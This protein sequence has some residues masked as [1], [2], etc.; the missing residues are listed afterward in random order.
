MRKLAP[1]VVMLLLIGG[2]FA[3][4]QP[5]GV[6]AGQRDAAASRYR[7]AELP[8]AVPPGLR[9]A[10]VRDVNPAYRHM[11]GWI[12]SVGAGVGINDLTGDG[13]PDEMCLVDS[14]SDALIV[15]SVPGT[16]AAGTFQPFVLTPSPALPYDASTMAPMGCAPGDFNHDGLMDLLAYYWG[17]T[18]VLYM[19]KR[20]AKQL[21]ASAY[22]PVEVVPN[23]PGPGGRYSGPLWNTNAVAVADFDGDGRTDIVIGNY[24]PDSPV[25]GSHSRGKVVMP[26][27]LSR[28]TNGGGDIVLRWDG[29]TPSGAPEY[30]RARDPFPKGSATGWTLA[31]AAADL[32]GSMTPELYVAND[33][34]HDHLFVNMS[35]PGHIRFIEAKGKR[36][37]T[38]P[39]SKVLG[40][41]SF[42]G[43]GAD[44]TDLAGDGRFDILVSNITTSFG[45]Q[46]SN[47]TWMNTAGSEAEMRRDLRRGVAAFDDRSWPMGLAQSGWSWDVKAGDFA[48]RG[49]QDVLQTAGFVKGTVNRWAQLQEIATMNDNLVSDPSFWLNVKD[50]DDLAGDQCPAFFARAKNGR[51]TDL[52]RRL[53][54]CVPVPTRGISIADTRGN[55]AL[56]FAI[57]RQW[58]APSFYQNTAPRLG[59]HLS[60]RLV[61][62]VAGQRGPLQA[63][64][65]PA[66]GATVTVRTSTGKTMIDQVD[67]GGGHSGKNDFGLHYGLG[68]SRAPVSATVAWRDGNGQAHR[69][70][71]RLAPG[72]HTLLLGSTIQEVPAR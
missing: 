45:L 58:G 39:K 59:E 66:V 15:T 72:S 68:E 5:P 16:K 32:D 9:N 29:A 64:G 12:S 23:R 49:T 71:V 44:F 52:S 30:T 34:D 55:G 33:F 1:P 43:M 14:R 54:L 13:R 42:K 62:P 35:K 65:T 41:D 2:L 48:N 36:T 50:G 25:L 31:A 20:D 22:E 7:F 37:P 6:S 3:L 51:Y 47:F 11:R 70:T 46:E 24:F 18:P 8:I 27:G 53:G 19:L 21:T 67:G 28:A 63:A 4:A 56:D 61:L 38:V 40:N 57:A 26:S 69:E 17:R 60:L 10:S